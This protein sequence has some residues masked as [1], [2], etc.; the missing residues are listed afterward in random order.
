LPAEEED[1]PEGAVRGDI[2]EAPASMEA[3]TAFFSRLLDEIE[4][5]TT[6]AE[7]TQRSIQELAA[8]LQ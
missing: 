3:Q 6:S 4:T 5:Y 7:V 8:V 2:W 1:M